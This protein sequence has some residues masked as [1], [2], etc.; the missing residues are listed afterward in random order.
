MRHK[1]F[2]LF[3]S[4]LCI[5][6]VFGNSF[7]SEVHAS[8]K[9]E[10]SGMTREY[11]NYSDIPETVQS[12]TDLTM[13]LESLEKVGDVYQAVY[14]EAGIT[15]MAANGS[16]SPQI[17]VSVTKQVVKTYS[18]F[19]SVPSSISYEEYNSTYNTWMKGTLFL[20]KTERL[21]TTWYATFEGTLTGTI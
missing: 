5:S 3:A 20:K 4:A 1:N 12:E 11:Q 10:S 13:Y 19:D 7:N 9:I 15:Q 17:V 8:E 21:G 18:N 16:V 2:L 14:S 6:F